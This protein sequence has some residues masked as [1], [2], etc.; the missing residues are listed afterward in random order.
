MPVSE[1]KAKL[2]VRVYPNADRNEVVSFTDGILRVKVSAPPVKG[3]ANTELVWFLSEL[4]NTS[5]YAISIVKGYTSRNKSVV[6]NGLSQNSVFKLLLKG[7]D[8]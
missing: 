3:M 8:F 4:L 5:R 2:H 7:K 1:N 6:I